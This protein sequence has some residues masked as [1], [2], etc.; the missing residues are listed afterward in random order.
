[1]HWVLQQRHVDVIHVLLDSQIPCRCN[2]PGQAP[3]DSLP[4]LAIHSI[5]SRVLRFKSSLT[6]GPNLLA[7][8][9]AQCVV[10]LATLFWNPRPTHSPVAP[11]FTPRDQLIDWSSPSKT[12]SPKTLT[13]LAELQVVWK[14]VRLL[15]LSQG[16]PQIMGRCPNAPSRL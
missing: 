8:K 3:V 11:G 9:L 13:G 15:I 1:M 12:L 5:V 2:G 6:S 14:E 4:C 7:A 10:P 16:T